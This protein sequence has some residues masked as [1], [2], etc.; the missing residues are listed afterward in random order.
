[1]WRSGSGQ[2]IVDSACQVGRGVVNAFDALL[3]WASERGSGAWSHWTEACRYL[4][5]STGQRVEPTQAAQLLSSLGHLECDW[6]HD[7]FAAAPS[8]AVL[9]PRSSGSVV[10]TGAR[11]RGL[12]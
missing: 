11:P 8:T 12:R 1:M 3:E 6:V 2:A 7:R 5:I 10:I 9:I 4:E